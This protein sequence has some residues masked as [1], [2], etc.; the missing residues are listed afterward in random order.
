[1]EIEYFIFNYW[2]QFFMVL[3]EKFKPHSDES[4]SEFFKSR[5]GS[6]KKSGSETLSANSMVI[7]KRFFISAFCILLESL[8]SPTTG[9]EKM[10]LVSIH[11]ML[12]FSGLWTGPSAA[13]LGLTI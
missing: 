7:I 13:K 6:A 9:N 11:R 12:P 8:N 4:G 10:S 2:Y 5:S 1:M 3:F